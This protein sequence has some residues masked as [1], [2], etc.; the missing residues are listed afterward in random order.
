MSYNGSIDLLPMI[1]GFVTSMV[2]AFLTIK[3]FL[4]FVEKIGMY[5]FVLYRVFLGAVLVLL[6]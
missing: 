2:F 6:I 3:Y 4:A 5:P 1:I